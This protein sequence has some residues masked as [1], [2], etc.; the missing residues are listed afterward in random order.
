MSGYVQGYV[1]VRSDEHVYG[2]RRGE[3]SDDETRVLARSPARL[4]ADDD[5]LDRQS[6]RILKDDWAAVRPDVEEHF[7]P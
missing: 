7:L 3:E 2:R 4:G 5:C 1:P 6:G